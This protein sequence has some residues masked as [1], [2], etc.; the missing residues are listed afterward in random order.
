MALTRWPHQERA[1]RDTLAAIQKGEHRICLS[2][3]TGMGK[4]L[5]AEDL[6]RSFLNDG[7]S[8]ALYSNRKLLTEQIFNQLKQSGISVGV[9]AAEFEQYSDPNASVQLCSIQTEHSRVIRRREKSGA[10]GD[11]GRITIPLARAHRV[12]ID[13]AHLQTGDQACTVFNEHRELGA[14]LIGITATPLGVSHVYKK[15]ILAGNNSEGRACGAL[16]PAHMKSCPELDTRKI[17]R[18]KTGEY[19]LA[20]IRKNVWSQAIYGSVHQHLMLY[21]PDIKPFII[22]A[23]GVEESVGFS[24]HLRSKGIRCAHIDGGDCYVDGERYKSDREARRQIIDEV[25]KGT[26]QGLTN[27]FVLREAVDIREL[28][29]GVLAT[30]IGSLLSYVQ[31]VGRILRSHPSMDHAMILDHGGNWW[32]HGSPNADRD[33]LWMEYF[34]DPDG[35]RL[36]TDVRMEEIRKNK[37]EEQPVNCPQ[38]GSIQNM[39]RSGKCYSC[40]LDLRGKR[41]R[42]V[43][44]RDGKLVDVTG[45]PVSQRRINHTPR[46]EQA[47]TKGVFAARKNGE[48]TF[49]QVR[50]WIAS[51]R[52]RGFEDLAGQYPPENIRLS[53]MN[54][55]DWFSPVV[56]VSMDRLH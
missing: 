48:M 8:V 18:V 31:I 1:V 13:E 22:F 52:M 43:I 55:R 16:L 21:N 47:W 6:I 39:P 44:Q 41:T 38:C 46:M 20:D 12:I 53:P 32:R 15:L 30:P 4:S 11:I 26:I 19:S 17:E 45:L 14:T 5:I 49:S 50:G 33:R 7:L 25:R 9:R 36:I 2:S 54:A 51:G 27:R 23:P 28:Y 42:K 10:T 3:P 35:E 34:Q 56:D 24:D 29:C 37:T 40:G